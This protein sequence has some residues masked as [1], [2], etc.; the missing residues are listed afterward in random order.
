MN[1]LKFNQY[2]NLSSS[3][4]LATLREDWTTSTVK[5]P[6]IANQINDQ[7]QFLND[8][9]IRK[10]NEDEENVVIPNRESFTRNRKVPSISVSITRKSPNGI[11]KE[12]KD[13]I[14]FKLKEKCRGSQASQST[15]DDS[16]KFETP[17]PSLSSSKST[18][19][20]RQ[21][22]LESIPSQPG[23]SK[24]VTFAVGTKDYDS[25]SESPSRKITRRKFKVRNTVA[26][27][28][29]DVEI[30]AALNN[31]LP[32]VKSTPVELPVLPLKELDSKL[33][34]PTQPRKR[35]G[36][37]IASP[38]LS[39][40]G[41]EQEDVLRIPNLELVSEASGRNCTPRKSV[42]DSHSPFSLK[43][44][45]E[46]FGSPV[47]ATMKSP[48]QKSGFYSARDRTSTNLLGT[49]I[50]QNNCI[51]LTPRTNL[52]PEIYSPAES[53]ERRQNAFII[54]RRSVLRP[55]LSSHQEY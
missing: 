5:L 54:N 3:A 30:V 39:D 18:N 52:L 12:P 47:Y 16:F 33:R 23:K 4:L 1:L 41:V 38:V 49:P 46:G 55:R 13:S 42:S 36:S 31:F 20:L 50:R 27:V 44:N 37:N 9:L 24:R 45:E 10:D 21:V 11:L 2:N 40:S 53:N 8:I 48:L 17:S 7:L 28:D 29:E 26:I 35:F 43:L 14:V 6:R 25:D 34:V 19:S 15:E 32:K 51:M 22:S